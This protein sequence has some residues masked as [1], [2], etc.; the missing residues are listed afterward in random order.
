MRPG[1]SLR[2]KDPA[3]QTFQ[4][5]TYFSPPLALVDLTC[6]PIDQ[7]LQSKQNFSMCLCYRIAKLYLKLFVLKSPKSELSRLIAKQDCSIWQLV[8]KMRSADWTYG[9]VGV[10]KDGQRY[11]VTK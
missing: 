6:V 10:L 3:I 11:P 1:R 7:F 4:G 8:H 5:P 9:A 2:R